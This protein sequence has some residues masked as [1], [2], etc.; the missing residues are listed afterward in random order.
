MYMNITYMYMYCTCTCTQTL[1]KTSLC[2]QCRII[3]CLAS[4]DGEWRHTAVAGR[5][6]SRNTSRLRI[7]LQKRGHKHLLYLQPDYRQQILEIPNWYWIL[8]QRQL[9]PRLLGNSLGGPAPMPMTSNR[10]WYSSRCSKPRASV[11]GP[12][13]SPPHLVQV[14][15]STPILTWGD[16]CR[17]SGESR[18]RLWA[19]Q[20]TKRDT[21]HGK[22]SIHGQ[23]GLNGSTYCTWKLLRYGNQ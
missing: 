23:W 21:R 20:S 19:V 11:D 10:C 14:K 17:L 12:T 6:K 8:P 1:T 16:C 2:T 5:W 7:R 4:K 13:T 3:T 9:D 22:V 18:V 15:A